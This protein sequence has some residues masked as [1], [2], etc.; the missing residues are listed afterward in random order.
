[1]HFTGKILEFTALNAR[2]M[3]IHNLIQED[4]YYNY[5][6]IYKI[7]GNMFSKYFIFLC[8]KFKEPQIIHAEWI[9][10]FLKLF[11]FSS[12]HLFPYNIW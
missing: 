7:Y 1:M 2:N 8:L 3:Y 12:F 6:E 4:W 9:F 5:W 11:L 10:N